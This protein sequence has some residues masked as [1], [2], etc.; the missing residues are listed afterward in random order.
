[1]GFCPCCGAE[2][3]KEQHEE[4]CIYY[5][6]ND[7]LTRDCSIQKPVEQVKEEGGEKE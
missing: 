6:V 2:R 3:L 4:E 1:M 5:G 7:N